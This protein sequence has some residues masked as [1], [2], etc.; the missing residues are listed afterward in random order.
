MLCFFDALFVSR[1]D[2]LSNVVVTAFMTTSRVVFVVVESLRF[3]RLLLV[4]AGHNKH[5]GDATVNHRER[6][7][8]D[9]LPVVILHA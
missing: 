5:N 9:T 6:V 2:E 7:Q 1:L 8:T 4:C 3:L